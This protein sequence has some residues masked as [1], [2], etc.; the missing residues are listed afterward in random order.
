MAGETLQTSGQLWTVLGAGIV[1]GLLSW[2]GVQFV[3]KQAIDNAIEYTIAQQPATVASV[4]APA[5]IP[6]PAPVA[7]KPVE[8]P[9]PPPAPEPPSNDAAV[10]MLSILQ[11]EGRLIDFLHEDL[12]GHPDDL[13]GAAVRNIHQESKGALD[14]HLTLTSVLDEAEGSEI[15][16]E[17]GFDTQ[18]IR[19]TGNVAGDPPFKGTIQHRGWRVDEI[20]LP[21][22]MQSQDGAMI[23]APAEVEIN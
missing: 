4:P 14:K 11:R 18:S 21:E 9:P 1:T 19:L 5:P 15:T 22:R 23:V 6:P 10:Q 16:L 3:G 2:A 17:E 7:P 20:D 13:V 8:P 12:S